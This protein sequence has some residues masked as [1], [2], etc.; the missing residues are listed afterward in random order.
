VQNY[1]KNK[2][3]GLGYYRAFVTWRMHQ[4]QP[5]PREEVGFER[6]ALSETDGAIT[7]SEVALS[8][9]DARGAMGVNLA[10]RGIQPVCIKIE[11]HEDIGFLVPP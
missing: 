8:A 1:A 5:R 11:N 7:V 6:R 2:E 4:L 9:D 10:G 3:G